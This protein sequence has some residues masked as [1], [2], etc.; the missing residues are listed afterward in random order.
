MLKQFILVSGIIFGYIWLTLWLDEDVLLLK[1]KA[2]LHV[3]V[4]PQH[5]QISYP[6]DTLSQL[7]PYFI[8]SLPG[9]RELKFVHRVLVTYPAWLPRLNIITPPP[10]PPPPIFFLAQK[11]Q[12]PW[13]F[14]CSTENS[15]PSLFVQ[16]LTFIV[17]MEMV[18]FTT[19]VF[20]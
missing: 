20:A 11:V 5:F 1:D 10:T 12:W 7:K 13:I 14:A 19:P 16:K 2:T 15:S 8:W 4:A 18:N 17:Y 6:L 3:F 9:S